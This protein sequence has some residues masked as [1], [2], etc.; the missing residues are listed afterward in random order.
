MYAID[1]DTQLRRFTRRVLAVIGLAALVLAA[2]LDAVDAATAD[3][4]AVAATPWLAFGVLAVVL[5]AVMRWAVPI[6]T[7][8]PAIVRRRKAVLRARRR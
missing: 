7:R 4:M 5:F 2:G 8:R 6:R 3:P 1:H